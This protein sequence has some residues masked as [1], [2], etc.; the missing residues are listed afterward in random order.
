MTLSPGWGRSTEEVNLDEDKQAVARQRSSCAGCRVRRLREAA[1]DRDEGCPGVAGRRAQHG[2]G[3]QVGVGRVP[4][5][6]DFTRQ[7]KRRGRG[8]EPALLAD[9]ELRQGERDV[10]PGEGGCGQGEA[11]SRCKQGDGEERG[12]HEALSL[13]HI[14]EPTR[15]LSISY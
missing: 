14:S 6:E 5:G 7:R 12:Q 9:A 2:A 15:L 3:G 4:D 1:R 11:G 8:A 13:I 10:R